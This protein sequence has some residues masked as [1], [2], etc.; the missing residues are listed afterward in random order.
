MLLNDH[1]QIL[2]I[3]QDDCNRHCTGVFK[4]VLILFHHS[5]ERVKEKPTSNST[6]GSGGA[7]KGQPA[8]GRATGSGM[9]SLQG[10]PSLTGERSTG[11]KSRK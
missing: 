4:N 5:D 6:G 8:Q 11:R 10:L 2:L 3:R 7:Q 9:S 1:I